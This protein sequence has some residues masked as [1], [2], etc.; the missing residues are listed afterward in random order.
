M[1]KWTEAR[2]FYE[3]VLAIRTRLAEASPAN[4]DRQREISV[5]FDRLGDTLKYEGKLAE[6]RK[7]Y[8]DALAIR[9]RLAEADAA[10]PDRQ[11]DLSIVE[12]P[13]ED[14]KP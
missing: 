1:G 6:A 2:K 7:F 12:K 5:S 3:E 11:R 14:S 9:K 4:A 10:N 8:E 13:R